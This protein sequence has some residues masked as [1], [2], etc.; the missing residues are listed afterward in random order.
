MHDWHTVRNAD[1]APILECTRCLELDVPS[2]SLG[3]HSFGVEGLADKVKD[4]M[5]KQPDRRRPD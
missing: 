5:R 3:A 4:S 2:Q 1:G